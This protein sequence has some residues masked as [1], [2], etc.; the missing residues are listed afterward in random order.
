MVG[1]AGARAIAEKLTKLHFLLL[2]DNRLT[3]DA[4]RRLAEGL[5]PLQPEAVLVVL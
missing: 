1:E 3:D 4:V 5:Q 2:G